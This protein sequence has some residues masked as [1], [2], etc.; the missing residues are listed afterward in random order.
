MGI[1]SVGEFKDLLNGVEGT[2]NWSYYDIA[3]IGDANSKIIII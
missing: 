3:L 2:P 1:L